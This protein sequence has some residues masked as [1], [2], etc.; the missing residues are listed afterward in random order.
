MT[1]PEHGWLTALRALAPDPYTLG[2][3]IGL[4]A[5][6]VADYLAGLPAA[7]EVEA[8][9]RAYV[10]SRA[11]YAIGRLKDALHVLEAGP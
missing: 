3:K 5:D 7:N 11:G 9:L 10:V 2:P 1:D 8:A 4:T 6:E